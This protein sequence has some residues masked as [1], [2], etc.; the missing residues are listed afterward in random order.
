[1]SAENSKGANQ[2][3]TVI[4]IV[5]DIMAV[6]LGLWILMYV[7]DANGG[8][9]VVLVEDLAGPVEAGVGIAQ[10]LDGLEDVQGA[11]G[12]AQRPEGQGEFG[13]LAAGHPGVRDHAAY[14][15]AGD[16][17]ALPVL[18]DTGLGLRAGQ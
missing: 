7:L 4:A 13:G 6:I 14:A 10:V 17:E 9:D 2:A 3:G 1:M 15:Q 12:L 11:V 5:A 8:N 16:D 18:L